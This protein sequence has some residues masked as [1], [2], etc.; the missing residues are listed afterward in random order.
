MYQLCIGQSNRYYSKYLTA[1]ELYPK[2]LYHGDHIYSSDGTVWLSFQPD[3]NPVV[4][5]PSGTAWTS[6]T[7]NIDATVAVLHYNGNLI[8]S[9]TSNEVLWSSDTAPNYNKCRL[10]VDN[11]GYAFIVNG[12]NEQIWRSDD[13]LLT[14]NLA[15][16]PFV[17]P[18][19]YLLIDNQVAWDE[20][21]THCQTKYNF[22]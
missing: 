7:S 9:S 19:S 5:T 10:V 8:V 12:K 1:T 18:S 11:S 13:N 20:A 2:Y 3:G 16:P 15:M 4:R 22:I 17:V 14:I 21:E 6:K